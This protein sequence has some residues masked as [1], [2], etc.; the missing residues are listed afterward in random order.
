M[1]I[2]M[3][4]RQKLTSG[5]YDITSPIPVKPGMVCPDDQCR[6]KFTLGQKFC[7]NCGYDLTEYLVTEMEKY[8][9]DLTAYHANE[10][11][12]FKEFKEDIFDEFELQYNPKRDSIFMFAFT[13]CHLD[14]FQSVF[15]FINDMKQFNLF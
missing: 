12:K 9:Q 5:R 7:T 11:A 6:T 1:V 3:D 8:K 4:V 10:A 13:K 2:M 15:E 14:G